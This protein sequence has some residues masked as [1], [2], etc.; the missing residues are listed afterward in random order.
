M[1]SGEVKTPVSVEYS[2]M[3]IVRLA[4]LETVECLEEQIEEREKNP[5]TS[6]YYSRSVARRARQVLGA[7]TAIEKVP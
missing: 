4:L 2:F 7:M 6:L 3:E 5:M 1:Q